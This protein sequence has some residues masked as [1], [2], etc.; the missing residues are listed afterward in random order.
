VRSDAIDYRYARSDGV[1]V[2]LD[3]ITL[4]AD[5]ASAC[6][7]LAARLG[8]QFCGIDLRRRPDG[9]HVCFEV[10]P[11]PGYS[12][13]ESETGQAI[14]EALVDYLMHGEG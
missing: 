2:D 7:A 4:P 8:L 12:Y 10:N 9:E 11:M 3:E 6:V 14:S 1:D 5:I 13:F